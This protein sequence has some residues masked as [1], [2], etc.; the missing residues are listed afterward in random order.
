MNR[1]L[2]Q[3]IIPIARSQGLRADG[4]IAAIVGHLDHM[5]AEWRYG[6]KPNIPY[7]DPLCRWAYMYRQVPAQ[8]NLFSRV[9]EECDAQSVELHKK[10][11]RDQLS[12]VV[13]GGGPGTELFGLAKYY[14]KRASGE[15]REQIDLAIDVIDEEVGWTENVDWIKSEIHQLYADE[16]GEKRGNWPARFNTN[17][18]T[19]KFSDVS[20]FGNLPTLF[21]KRDV[22]VLNFIIS[23]EH[24]AARCHA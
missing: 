2:R 1:I 20:G 23:E 15:D 3:N 14:L 19:I 9:I 7:Q 13:F 22:F 18:I 12:M 11:R 10:L 6:R 24:D 4:V 21:K 17:A 8:A 16:F 5:A